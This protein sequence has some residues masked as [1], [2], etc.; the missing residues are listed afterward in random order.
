MSTVAAPADRLGSRRLQPGLLGRD[1]PREGRVQGRGLQAFA[2]TPMRINKLPSVHS[3][4]PAAGRAG[5]PA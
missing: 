4:P 2:F 1:H 3:W 5:A